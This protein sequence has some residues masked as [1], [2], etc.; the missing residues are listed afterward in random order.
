MFLLNI[1]INQHIAAESTTDANI[2]Y[3]IDKHS[4]HFND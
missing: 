2:A 1:P 4:A 3:I